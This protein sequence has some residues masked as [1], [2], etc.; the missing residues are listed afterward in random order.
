MVSIINSV[1][2]IGITDNKLWTCIN[3]LN[4]FKLKG[5]WRIWYIASDE[6]LHQE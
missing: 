6:L 1:K 2:K 3:E 4:K 5:E